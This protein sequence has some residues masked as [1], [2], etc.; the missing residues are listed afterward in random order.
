MEQNKKI[1]IVGNPN[2]KEVEQC[3]KCLEF[4][5]QIKKVREDPDKIEVSSRGLYIGLLRN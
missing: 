2:S 3:I 4:K 1:L 5:E